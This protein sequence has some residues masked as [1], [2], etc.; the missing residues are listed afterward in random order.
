MIWTEIK[1]A[2]N[3]S[4]GTENFQPLDEMI[5]RMAENTASAVFS[6]QVVHSATI[7]AVPSGTSKYCTISLGQF[8]PPADGTYKIKLSASVDLRNTL[9]LTY[10]LPVVARSVIEG[11]W[12]GED[13]GI[14][15]YFSS[16]YV[17]ARGAVVMGSAPN[18]L[19]TYMLH[20]SNISLAEADR[21]KAFEKYT[22]NSSTA[23]TNAQQASSTPV[24]ETFSIENLVS[25]KK[26]EAACLYLVCQASANNT[27][28]LVKYN[29]IQTD[30]CYELVT[31][32]RFQ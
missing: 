23:K 26:G 10:Y 8:I 4:L 6:D 21:I 16:G 19:G 32:G 2:L 1:K 13:E 20:K 28:G 27:W 14:Y 15:N 11:L 17:P 25:L 3:S 18:L 5:R 30:I 9:A 7:S 31:Q 24:T 29:S 12:G 22:A